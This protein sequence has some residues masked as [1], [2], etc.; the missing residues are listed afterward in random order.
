VLNPVIPGE[1]VQVASLAG[2][3]EGRGDHVLLS[4]L[5]HGALWAIPRRLSCLVRPLLLLLEEAADS[6][7][8][9]ERKQRRWD[10][11]SSWR[12]VVQ[13]DRGH[14][15]LRDPE[16]SLQALLVNHGAL[17]PV[18]ERQGNG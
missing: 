14:P 9:P 7:L 15:K 17:R 6:A 1:V 16:A 5:I 4:G 2:G 18:L 3:D 10:G 12:I 13:H 8:K 11:I